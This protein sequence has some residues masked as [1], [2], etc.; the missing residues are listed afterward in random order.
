M[1]VVLGLGNPG[2]SYA[3]TRH[4]IGFWCIDAIAREND[5]LLEQ[6]RRNAILG[7]GSIAGNQVVL[8]RSRTYMNRSGV[9]ARYLLDR[10]SIVP[11]E[12]L[13]LYDDMD[14]P[15]GKMRIRPQG[16]S[17]GHNGIKDIIAELRT[18]QFPRVRIGI[19]HPQGQDAVHFVL[20]SFSAEESKVVEDAIVQ[21][22]KAV[23]WVI[24]HGLESAMDKFNRPLSPRDE[25]CDAF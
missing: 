3:R 10:Y 8:A 17:A 5:I 16:S 21:S 11:S 25:K 6:R 12:L 24:Q 13:V 1:M 20:G 2:R 7:E 18:S 9:P 22:V 23:A 15:V 4:N 14:L 19:G